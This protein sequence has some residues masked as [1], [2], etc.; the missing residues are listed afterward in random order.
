ME[1]TN[2]VLEQDAVEIASV[3][4]PAPAKKK[5]ALIIIAAAAVVVWTAIVAV[6]FF[7]IGRESFRN[8][9]E[10]ARQF[11]SAFE[12]MGDLFDYDDEFDYDNDYDFD[13]DSFDFD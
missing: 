8:R 2:Q 7:F 12:G 6:S 1:E 4:E 13:F 3:P 9:K 5:T 11:A 10:I